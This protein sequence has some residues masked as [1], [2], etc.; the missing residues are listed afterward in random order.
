MTSMSYTKSVKI[1]LEKEEADALY[2]TGI[3]NECPAGFFTP[4]RKVWWV[5][6]SDDGSLPYTLCQTC[7]H[8]NHFGEENESVK[9]ML[10]PIMMAGMPCSCEGVKYVDAF[11][12]NYNDYKIGIYKITPKTVLM[13]GTKN[14]DTVNILT[15]DENFSYAISIIC[16]NLNIDSSE[17]FECKMFDQNN[18][19]ENVIYTAPTIGNIDTENDFRIDI[20]GT[21]NDTTHLII[22]NK[23]VLA[24]FS[25]SLKRI[26]LMYEGNVLIDFKVIFKYID[27]ND[28]S[29]SELSNLENDTDDIIIHK[30]D[31]EK[32]VI[33]DI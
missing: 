6:E 24:E 18:V 17:S 8:E 12:I 28:V 11:P 22:P 27:N 15:S 4:M 3:N 23:F 31:D 10:K 7:Y 20:I 13:N 14:D 25:E 29:K 1:Y 26:Q 32:V 19:A 5:I 9:D 33:V 16:P 21:L 30:N 2:T